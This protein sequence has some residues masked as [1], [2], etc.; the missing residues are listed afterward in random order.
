MRFSVRRGG[1]LVAT[2]VPSKRT[3][4]DRDTTTTEAAID[5]FGF[6]QL[7][8]SLGDIAADGTTTVRMYWKPL[9]TLTWLG[10]IVMAFGGALSLSDRRLRIGAPR[11]ARRIALAPAE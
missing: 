6:S 1:A 9:V 11:K 4:D 10:A 7:Y 3:F 5:T 2:M 8:L